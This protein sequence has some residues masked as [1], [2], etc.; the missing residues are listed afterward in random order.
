MSVEDVANE[1]WKY[2]VL[3]AS[4]QACSDMDNQICALYN[5]IRVQGSSPNFPPDPKPY[6]AKLSPKQTQVRSSLDF[7]DPDT[8]SGDPLDT[9][10]QLRTYGRNYYARYDYEGYCSIWVSG[11][12][13]GGGGFRKPGAPVWVGRGEEEEVLIRV[14][15]GK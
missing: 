12:R 14:L 4:V 11:F 6:K 9:K 3:L 7:D 2:L 10:P 1:H 5:G 13:G 8:R 15:F